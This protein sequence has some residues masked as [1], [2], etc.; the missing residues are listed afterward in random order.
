MPDLGNE[1][2]ADGVDII[3]RHTFTK[4]REPQAMSELSYLRL[5]SHPSKIL[6]RVIFNRLKAKADE[7]LA[8]EQAVV[9][10][11]PE[12]NRTDLQQSSHHREAPTTPA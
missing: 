6:L 4:E 11:R 1:G 7:L 3:A 10:T 9:E 12:H 2:M 8:E 5:I